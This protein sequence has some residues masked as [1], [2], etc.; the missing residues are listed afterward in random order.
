MQFRR[1]R[2]GANQRPSASKAIPIREF[3]Q[4]FSK[5]I[6][7][8]RDKINHNPAKIMQRS[9][10]P[11]QI[12]RQDRPQDIHCADAPYAGPQFLALIRSI[13]VPRLMKIIFLYCRECRACHSGDDGAVTD[14]VVE[15][16]TVSANSS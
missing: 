4:Y 8:Q 16:D 9:K 15:S 12:S 13:L 7:T 14:V 5:I 6:K 10:P 3:S 1:L 2:L 11:L